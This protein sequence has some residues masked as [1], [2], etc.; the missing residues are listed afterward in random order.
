ME[1]PA[2][3]QRKVG[4]KQHAGWI[5]QEE[6]GHG[7]P[8]MEGRIAIEVEGL[9][10]AE[11]IRADSPRHSAQD[12]LDAAGVMEAGE[13][14]GPDT[15]MAE[16]MQEVGPRRRA[17]VDVARS[18]PRGRRDRAKP[19]TRDVGLVGLGFEGVAAHEEGECEDPT[20]NDS[21]K[22]LPHRLWV[23]APR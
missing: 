11:N 6:I 12:V 4:T 18:T 20:P 2:D 23:N 13:V 16:A 7:A 21:M 15:E 8:K 14:A 3:V 19:G 10:G 9:Q 1:G 17:P 5:E 22:G